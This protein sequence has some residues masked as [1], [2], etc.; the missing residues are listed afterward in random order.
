M[1]GEFSDSDARP[2]CE[3]FLRLV[4]EKLQ[5]K[6]FAEKPIEAKIPPRGNNDE[7]V[8]LPNPISGPYSQSSIAKTLSRLTNKQFRST[9]VSRVWNSRP[10]RI[11]ISQGYGTHPI[12]NV[13]TRNMTSAM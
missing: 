3:D 10:A 2:H 11:L 7:L 12:D 6:T 13:K 1:G 4:T 8:I 5:R 9:V